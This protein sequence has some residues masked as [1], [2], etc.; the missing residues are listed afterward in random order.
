MT[1]TLVIAAFLTSALSAMVGM[2]GGIL[3]FAVM[4][5]FLPPV[6]LIPIHGVTQ[7]GSNTSRCL[8]N[9]KSIR[10]RLL[11]P[12]IF[13]TIIGMSLASPFIQKMDSHYFLLCLG[14]FIL[15]VTWLPKLQGIPRFKGK[16]F[17]LGI[18]QSF[19]S[20]LFGAVGLLGAPF[21]LN[22]GLKKEEIIATKASAQVTM[23][24]LKTIIFASA[25]FAFAQYWQLLSL[26]LIAVLLGSYV[27]KMLLL[28]IN[29]RLFYIAFRMT[30][31]VLALRLIYMSLSSL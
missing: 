13:G 6:A 11:I 2:G 28:K 24:L 4:A 31:T 27:G 21:Y 16:F 3:L 26:L 8:L 25:G 14:S 22:E 9:L 29:E 12:F 23:H 19:L 17:F 30:I 1:I 7:L 20:L 5:S 10:L 15:I 18:C